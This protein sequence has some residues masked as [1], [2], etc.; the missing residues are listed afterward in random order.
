MFRSS[1]RKEIDPE[2]SQAP[3]KS[4][5]LPLRWALILLASSLASIAVASV[6]GL[7]LA[8]GTW[9]AVAVALDQLIA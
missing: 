3:K 5:R 2:H 6:A 7:P 9:V 4:D 1:R 8:I